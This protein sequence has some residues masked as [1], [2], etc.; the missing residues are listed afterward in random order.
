MIDGLLKHGATFPTIYV[1]GTAGPFLGHRRGA[2]ATHRPGQGRAVDQGDLAGRGPGR[3]RRARKT[4]ALVSTCIQSISL[5]F[6]GQVDTLADFGLTPRKA[7][8]V[9]PEEQVIAAAKAKA[10]RAARHTM[11]KKQKA[12][13]KGTVAPTPAPAGWAP[14]PA[15]LRPT[16]CAARTRGGDG[17][18]CGGA[19]DPGGDAG[20]SAGGPSAGTSRV[21]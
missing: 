11:G 10:T 5:S 16:A 14:A 1:A 4:K 13:I 6:A 18:F 12:A 17:G 15:P 2:A 9:T 19:G 20:G 8:V 3:E 21:T 7:R